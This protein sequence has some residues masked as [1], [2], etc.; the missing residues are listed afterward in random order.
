MRNQRGH[1]WSEEEGG[2]GRPPSAVKLASCDPSFTFPYHPVHENNIYL[3]VFFYYLFIYLFVL[4]YSPLSFFFFSLNQF[5]SCWYI[6]LPHNS[7]QFF[8]FHNHTTCRHFFFLSILSQVQY[9]HFFKLHF[10]YSI[11]NTK[12][13]TCSFLFYFYFFFHPVKNFYFFY[14]FFN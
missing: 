5:L 4:Y 2:L 14:F 7:L 13:S 9:I 3:F 6:Y 11:N 8:L 1:K 12:H 10:Y